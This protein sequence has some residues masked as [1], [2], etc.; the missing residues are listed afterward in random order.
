[1]F[2]TDETEQASGDHWLRNA[3]SSEKQV[4]YSIDYVDRQME[5]FK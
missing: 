3:S 2:W 4:L 1:M 5:V